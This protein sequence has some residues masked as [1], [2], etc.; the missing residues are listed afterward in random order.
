M[1]L[2]CL[3][4][5]SASLAQGKWGVRVY[6]NTDIFSV[7]YWVNSQSPEEESHVSFS[8]FSGAAAYSGR[9]YTHELELSVPQINGSS[10]QFAFPYKSRR[11]EESKN[12]FSSYSIRYTIARNVRIS[13]SFLFVFG[14]ALNPYFTRSENIP[15]VETA[16]PVTY[17]AFGVSLNAVAGI[18]IKATRS[19]SFIVDCPLKLFDYYHEIREVRNPAIP[20]RQQKTPSDETKFIMSAF[21][22][23]LGASYLFG[24]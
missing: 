4:T 1:T 10:P 22:L 24:R 15:Q 9:I 13:E 2:I 21:T 11:V 18:N 6:Q 19:L 8:R 20:V 14:A 16:F 3:S 23:R 5:C 7:F 12:R 17:N